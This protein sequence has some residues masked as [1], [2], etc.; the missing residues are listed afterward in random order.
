MDAWLQLM[1]AA[2]E[3]PALLFLLAFLGTFAVAAYRA[4]QGLGANLRPLASYRA[5][6]RLVDESLET[7]RPIY[8]SL[9]AMT[10]VGGGMAESMAGLALLDR[11]ATR[12]A[13]GGGSI[14]V[15]SGDAV[16]YVAARGILRRAYKGSGRGRGAEIAA[17]GLFVGSAPMALAAGLDTQLARRPAGALVLHGSSR[18]EGFWLAETHR[19]APIEQVGGSTDPAAAGL[20]QTAVDHPLLGE[21]MFAG[22]AYLGG[23]TGRSSLK[24]ED[25]M[26]LLIILCVIVGVLLISLG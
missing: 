2:P 8:L 26:R 5:L 17:D 18:E 9:G 3:A 6:D 24:C 21:E 22:G 10:S 12:A 25:W 14:V 7:G 13:L 16:S 4:R 11:L 1:V 15:A 20:V 23:K 19:Q